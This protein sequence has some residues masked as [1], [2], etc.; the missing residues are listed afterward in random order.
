MD[1]KSGLYLDSSKRGLSC[2]FFTCS[3]AARGKKASGHPFGKRS[4]GGSRKSGLGGFTFWA[5]VLVFVL[6]L[7]LAVGLYVSRAYWPLESKTHG[8]LLTPV[9]SLPLNFAAEPRVWRIVLVRPDCLDAACKLELAK[10]VSVHEATG[11][12]FDRVASVLVTFTH[13]VD[14]KLLENFKE[15]SW[16]ELHSAESVDTGVFIMDPDGYLILKY[17]LDAQGADL[18][19]DLRHLLKVSQSG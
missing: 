16:F 18:L 3:Q 6:P 8:E 17:A 14:K 13:E 2:G 7:V 9:Q 15:V 5:V 1:Y 19:Q 10:I 11:K 12:D 4:V